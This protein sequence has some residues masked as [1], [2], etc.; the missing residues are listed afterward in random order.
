MIGLTY[1]FIFCVPY[2][3]E[4]KQIIHLYKDV[5]MQTLFTDNKMGTWLTILTSLAYIDF[6]IVTI[7]MDNYKSKKN[8]DVHEYTH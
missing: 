3:D 7:A 1:L 4:R 6:V 5:H 2:R 8:K